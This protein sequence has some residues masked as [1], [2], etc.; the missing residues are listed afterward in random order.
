MASKSR[1]GKGLGALFPALPGE[2]AVSDEDSS[3]SV[4][5]KA[6]EE[7]A[8]GAV[9]KASPT[10]VSANV[11]RETSHVASENV[12][13]Q[14][15]DQ[16]SKQAKT[17]NQKNV[18]RETSGKLSQKAEQDK[19]LSAK[20]VKK[21]NS[22][23][24]NALEKNVSRETSPSASRRRRE[25]PSLKEGM[26]H[27]SDLFFGSTVSDKAVNTGNTDSKTSTLSEKGVASNREALPG[28]ESSNTSTKKQETANPTEL[29]PVQGGYLVELEL[30]Q[31][32]PN[33]NQPRT[34]FDEDELK[35]LAASLKEVG[36]LQPV[37]VRKRPANQKI[38]QQIS[39]VVGSS[40]K[41]QQQNMD[42]EYEL[43]MGERRWRAAHL[44]GLKTI[45]AIK[46]TTDDQMLRD[47]LLENLHRVALNPLE[48]SAAYQQMMED[49]GLTQ[50]QLA[51]S[52]SKS[53]SQ[54][55][56]TLRLLNLPPSV[57]KK[58]A[59]GVLSAGHA[60]ALL[61]LSSEEEMEKLANRIIAEGLSVRSTEEIV[62]MKSGG[63]NGSKKQKSKKDN[64]WAQSLIQ[65]NLENRFDTKVS[66][67]GSKQHGRIEIV[68]SSPEDM[69]RIVSLLMPGQG[70]KPGTENGGEDGWV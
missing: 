50:E 56:N 69:N 6:H 10:S 57:Q 34:I 24:K 63:E 66:I 47:A 62:A 25:M 49:F 19:K 15:A 51:K 65:H 46:T 35:E 8:K 2:P 29:K 67:K 26:A 21:N 14:Q 33:A 5:K 45:P 7:Q 31:I 58:V 55:A 41:H 13:D 22:Q 38:R 53:R 32:G 64:P 3:E 4:S 18:S 23:K 1:L 42:S 36:V 9:K 60:R 28:T 30:D 37:V 17:V 40:N 43:I 68:F 27:P 39:Q 70:S 61:G 52:V 44:A 16:S 54:I 48:E 59:A 11:S 20:S 12:K